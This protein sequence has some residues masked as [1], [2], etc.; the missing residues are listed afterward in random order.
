MRLFAVGDA[1]QSIYEFTGASPELLQR[2]SERDDVETVRLRL[3]YRSGSD[4]VSASSF[5]LGEDRDYEAAEGAALGKIHFHVFNGSYDNQAV[6]VFNHILRDIDTRHPDVEPGDIAFVYPAAWIGDAIAGVA[7]RAGMSV[8]RTDTNSLY[9][10]SSPLMRWLEQCA[11]WCCTGW[12]SGTPRLRQIVGQG[13][14]IFSEELSSPEAEIEFQRE[15]VSVLWVKRKDTA[16]LGQWLV[17]VR[18][19][20]LAPLIAKCKTVMDD[21]EVLDTFISRASPGGDCA[22]MTLD[23]FGGQ[24]GR[25]DCF[26]LSTLHSSKG[27]E[28]RFVIMFGMDQGRIPR[29]NATESEKREA[30][31]L[32]YVGFTRAKE[33]LFIVHTEGRPSPFVTEVMRRLEEQ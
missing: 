24:S 29:G 28:F 1:D 23:Q 30:R 5:A 31:R 4:I 11:V 25:R 10:R 27:R 21:G 20:L 9:P 16:N 15:L 8:I 18:R 6:D 2:L 22:D 7:K 17:E 19:E 3:N 13:V 26:Q 12:R 14:R 33:E 32:F